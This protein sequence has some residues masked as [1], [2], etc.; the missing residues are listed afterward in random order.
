M[1]EI[2]HT[3]QEQYPGKTKEGDKSCVDRDEESKS[4]LRVRNVWV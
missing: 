4:C 3:N 2:L 1:G